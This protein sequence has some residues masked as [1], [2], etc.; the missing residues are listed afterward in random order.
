[1]LAQRFS[2]L[3]ESPIRYAA[4]AMDP[5][6]LQAIENYLRINTRAQGVPQY[7]QQAQNALGPLYQQ[8]PHIAPH[9]G[10]VM[11]GQQDALMEYLDLLNEHGDMRGQPY[12]E[13]S[14]YSTPNPQA[15]VNILAALHRNASRGQTPRQGTLAPDT[16]LRN[17][18]TMYSQAALEHP[19]TR[20]IIRNTMNRRL[21]G[22]H[23]SLYDAIEYIQEQL[24]RDAPQHP[25]VTGLFPPARRSMDPRASHEDLLQLH[26]LTDNLHRDPMFGNLVN[27]SG[28]VAR[29]IRQHFRENLIP[30][31]AE[32]FG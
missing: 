11:L 29:G 5:A 8:H 23:D 24:S 21:G 31:L 9:F 10:G 19:S 32:N 12:E 18:H 2:R 7:H 1:M 6:H 26:D 13:Q 16:D 3:R 28:G 22:S 17:I 27:S 20:G 30:H 15:L 25:G 14:P 4:A